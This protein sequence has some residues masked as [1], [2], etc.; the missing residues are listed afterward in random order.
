[1]IPNCV[2]SQFEIIYSLKDID[3]GLDINSRKAAFMGI[4]EA[5]NTADF[6]QYDFIF[7][8]KNGVVNDIYIEKIPFVGLN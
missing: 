3:A 8:F 5:Y 2:L 7:Y 1:M 4:A 6:K